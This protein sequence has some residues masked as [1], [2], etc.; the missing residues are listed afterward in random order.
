MMAYEGLDALSLLTGWAFGEGR[1]CWQIGGL[2]G[3]ASPS[4]GLHK[5]AAYKGQ[6][7]PL[8]A[9]IPSP[10]KSGEGR[11]GLQIGGPF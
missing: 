2:L 3:D 8:D 1:A 4:Q 11:A 10:Q 7:R 6:E 9:V 5:H